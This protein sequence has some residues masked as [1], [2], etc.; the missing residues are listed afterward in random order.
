[1][2]PADWIG[3]T[4]VATLLAAFALSLR[5]T[6]T[7]KSRLY[8][9]MNLLGAGLACWA[10]VL[11]EYWPFVVLEGTWA[12]AALAALVRRAAPGQSQPGTP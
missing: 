5:G 3:A 4:G 9:W 11:I 7:A 6:L 1:M 2:Q 12:A 10:S 8:Q